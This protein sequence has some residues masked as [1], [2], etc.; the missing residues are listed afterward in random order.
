MLGAQWTTYHKL[1]KYFSLLF[2]TYSVF[3]LVADSFVAQGLMRALFLFDLLSTAALA[4]A[5]T[6]LHELSLTDFA[7]YRGLLG[8]AITAS[9]VIYFNGICPIGLWRLTRLL[10]PAGLALLLGHYTAQT[11]FIW[12]TKHIVYQ[13]I[14]GSVLYAFTYGAALLAFYRIR[15][16]WQT[17]HELRSLLKFFHSVLKKAK[18]YPNN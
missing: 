10:I 14:L 8:L 2:L 5:L 11:I 4:V 17:S 13:A 12:E 6:A 18:H 15:F 1:L 16:I 7:L 9:I 3:A